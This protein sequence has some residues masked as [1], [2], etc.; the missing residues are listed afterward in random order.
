[1]SQIATGDM[2]PGMKVEMD[3]T[4]FLV[5]NTEF[6]KPGK[7]QAFNRIRLKN[8]LTG[9]VVEKTFKSGEKLEIADVQETSMRLLYVQSETAVFMHDETFEQ[10]EV[11]LTTIKENKQWL[12]DDL[13][14]GIHCGS[15]KQSALIL[16]K[17]PNLLRDTL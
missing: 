7:G 16:N 1:M 14:Y 6:V 4:P 9:R 12:K 3:N 13:L 11:E 15:Q 8:I 10:V 17:N 5:I 2:K